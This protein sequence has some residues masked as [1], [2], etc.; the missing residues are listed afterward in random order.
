MTAGIRWLPERLGSTTPPWPILVAVSAATVAIA[1]GARMTTA[2]AADLGSVPGAQREP[3]VLAPAMSPAP[4]L[5][6][7]V[8]GVTSVVTPAVRP[9]GRLT[10]EARTLTTNPTLAPMF[11]TTAGAVA[12]VSEPAAGA[13]RRLVGPLAG[14]AGERA[15]VARAASAVQARRPMRSALSLRLAELT[16]INPLHLRGPGAV[17]VIPGPPAPWSPQPPAAASAAGGASISV[18]LGIAA[19]RWTVSLRTRPPPRSPTSI[20]QIDLA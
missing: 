19:G 11:D 16:V 20:K 6:R 2:E 3:A 9:I 4:N 5:Y 12:A 17:P 14:P 15:A 7:P 1:L 8:H 18:T 13:L 10:R